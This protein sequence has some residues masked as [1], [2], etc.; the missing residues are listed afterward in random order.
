MKS[1]EVFAV[2]LALSF[3]QGCSDD[4]GASVAADVEAAFLGDLK[5]WIQNDCDCRGDTLC[6]DTDLSRTSDDPIL[7]CMKMTLEEGGEALL[8]AA[9]CYVDGLASVADCSAQQSSCVNEALLC[10]VPECTNGADIQLFVAA[11]ELCD[12]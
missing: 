3:A 5:T 12:S 11:V 1:I 10:Q 9:E 4:S 6:D 2:F 7:V 8:A